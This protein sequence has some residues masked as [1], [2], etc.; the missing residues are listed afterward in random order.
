MAGKFL[1]D[2]NSYHK[3]ANMKD[4]PGLFLQLEIFSSQLARNGRWE[5]SQTG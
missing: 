1:L 2:A 5:F 3:V 4:G